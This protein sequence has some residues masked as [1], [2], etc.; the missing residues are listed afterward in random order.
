MSKPVIAVIGV[1][2]MG[3][4]IAQVFALAGHR[5]RIFDE[6]PGALASAPGRIRANLDLLIERGMLSADAADEALARLVRAASVEEAVG[7]AELVVEAVF[8]NLALKHR[9]LAQIEAACPPDAVI[10]SSTSNYRA[11]A[12]ASALGRPERFL[13][14]HFWSPPHIIPLVEVVP[15]A[16]TAP[17][18]V[19]RAQ[20]LLRAAGRRPALIRRDLPG[21]VGNRLQ[22]ALRREAI[23]LVDQ[24]VASPEDID[25]IARLSFGLRLP[26]T[27]PLETAD[28]G[29][30]DLSLAIQTS[31]L[32]ELDRSTEPTPT[33]RA[34]VARGELGAKAGRGFFAWTAED[35]ARRVRRR[36]RALLDLLS[37][38][39]AYD[40]GEPPLAGADEQRGAA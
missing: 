33:L 16:K 23:A 2:T 6:H 20:E 36:D 38:V 24:G 28:L 31:L 17:A 19:E 27:G 1:G 14:T 12:L 9:V 40:A 34:K 25:L 30:L 18:T 32:P 8:E 13:V 5:V 4:G 22:H 29:G 39:E 35:H 7:G 21:F 15:S 11:A 37:L 10:A 26:V 3:H